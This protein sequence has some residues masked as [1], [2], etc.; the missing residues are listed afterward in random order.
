MVRPYRRAAHTAL[1]F[2][3]AVL[4]CKPDFRPADLP[5]PPSPPAADAVA[6][7]TDRGPGDVPRVRPPDGV[8]V[9][10]GLVDPAKL[11]TSIDRLAGFGTRHTLSDTVSEVR[12]IGAARRWIEA[13]L[14]AAAVDRGGAPKLEVAFDSHRI[15][16]DGKRIDRDV[17]VVNVVATL[18]GTRPEAMQRRIYVVAHYDSRASDPMDSTSDA[19]GANDDGSGVALVLELARVLAPRSLDATV[20][21][22]A[23]AGEEQGLVGARAHAKAA[24][25]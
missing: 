25:A 2:A 23:T 16:P 22:M 20:V 11:R 4:G 6:S 5:E 3:L 21:F 10:L 15:A 12:G 14:R 19:P 18:P 9:V 13:E 17:D 8:D 1:P 24:R 7:A